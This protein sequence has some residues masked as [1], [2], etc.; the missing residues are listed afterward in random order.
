M[1]DAN[2]T[3]VVAGQIYCSTDSAMY[4]RTKGK[5]TFADVTDQ[6]LFLTVTL[7][8]TATP[9]L[10]QLLPGLL[11]ELRQQRAQGPPA[12]CTRELTR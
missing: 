4:F 2:A 1:L 6:L 3:D 11:L 10:A 7:D 8:S 9:G 5:S 12:A